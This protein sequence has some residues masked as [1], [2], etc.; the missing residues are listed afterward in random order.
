MAG[1]DLELTDG[2]YILPFNCLYVE[3]LVDATMVSV[4]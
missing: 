1:T 3:L 4:V 2:S